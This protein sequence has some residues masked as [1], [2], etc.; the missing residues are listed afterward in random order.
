MVSTGEWSNTQLAEF[1]AEI[2]KATDEQS[3]SVL[4]VE[5]AAEAVEAEI[6]AFVRDGKVVHSVGFYDGQAP[7][8]ALLEVCAGSRRELDMGDLGMF[9][10]AVATSD[11]RPG[12][13]L[14]LGR[15]GAEAFSRQEA[16]LLGAMVRVLTLTSNMLGMVAKERELK[17]QSVRVSQL[18]SDLLANMSHEI[19]TPMNGIIGMTGL[20][21]GTKLDPEQREYAET[22]RRSSE[23]LLGIIDDIL[24]F[25]KIEAGKLE[26]ESISFELRTVLEEVAELLSGAAEQKGLE[27][28]AIMG[29]EIPTTVVGDPGRL[30]QVLINLAGNAIKFTDK[31]EVTIR[32]SLDTRQTEQVMVRFEVTDTGI[33]IAPKNQ[34]LLFE[35]FS[36]A[37]ASTTRIYG[38]TGLGLTIS[39]QLVEMMHGKIGVRSILGAGSTF[40]FTSQLQVDLA[41]SEKSLRPGAESIENLKVLVVDDNETNRVL[42]S[43]M[44]S[45]AGVEVVQ[46]EEAESALQAL[47]SN[48]R[49]RPFDAAILDVRLPKMDGV[50]LAAE[51]WADPS[52]PALAVVLV[53]SPSQLSAARSEDHPGVAGYLAKP[54]KRDQILKCLSRVTCKES[55]PNEGGRIAVDAILKEKERS[56]KPIL[57]VE[58]NLVNQK[59]AVT[60]LEKY[61]FR[62]DTAMNGEEAVDA[63]QR[64]D[65]SAILMDCRMPIMD[66]YQATKRIRQVEGPT[67]HTPII[68]VTA[69]AM[70]EDQ[71]KCFEA[72]MDDFVSKPIRPDDLVHT[73]SRWASIRNDSA[74]S[75]RKRPAGTADPLSGATP[76]QIG[77]AVSAAAIE[78]IRQ[79]GADL[80]SDLL[81]EI[82]GLYLTECPDK[83]RQIHQAVAANDAVAAGNAGHSLKGSSGNFGAARLV[84][85]S[86][87]IERAGRS[88]DLQQVRALLS[89]LEEAF[90]EVRRELTNEM[91]AA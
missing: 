17:D 71:N 1:L 20:M 49:A 44:L 52:I 31:G 27:I 6:G 78:E 28:A 63:V 36:Q 32:A 25:S 21:L 66:G 7:V 38:G 68:A 77:P 23:A 2:S 34:A 65:Y 24:D 39:K 72:G 4:A 57:V 91:A 14:I 40:W 15:A 75:D 43:E 48:G 73:V 37:D 8:Q 81:T 70:H 85:V 29:R 87:K 3:A 88:G 90:D 18:K 12:D 86:S 76:E 54:I 82:V 59:V 61:G 84:S 13:A 42:M 41:G 50:A 22:A 35:A 74:T 9:T 62:A 60:I 55:S 5:R 47:R 58:D 56:R 30:R 69:S 11:E 79:L 16:N 83:I 51:I 45:H 67:K 89:E 33:G 53:S 26:L 46:L 19:R 64:E 10:T 80:G